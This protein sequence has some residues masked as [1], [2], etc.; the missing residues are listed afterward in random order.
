MG[1]SRRL[2]GR[3][4]LILAVFVAGYLG[5]TVGALGTRDVGASH[6]FSDVPDNAF[7]HDFVQFL[8][9]NGITAGCGPGL[10]CGEQAVTRGQTAVFLKKLSDLVDQ[11][12]AAAVATG[13]FITAPGVVDVGPFN[14]C[15]G[16]DQWQHLSPNSS[17]TRVTL[18]AS[19]TSEAPG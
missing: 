19:C 9:D 12:V 2:F 8:V 14:S 6:N 18:P 4:V 5:A 7:Y 15:F 11:R 16:P 17:S 3:V 1:T 10:F 13:A